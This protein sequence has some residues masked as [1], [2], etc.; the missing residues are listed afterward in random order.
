MNGCVVNGAGGEILSMVNDAG[1][2]T[3]G[4]G[5]DLLYVAGTTGTTTAR[6]ISGRLGDDKI[7]NASG[8]STLRDAIATPHPDGTS[9]RLF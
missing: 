9:S 8:L 6:V 3:G 7:V 5:D 2:L 1:D 4:A